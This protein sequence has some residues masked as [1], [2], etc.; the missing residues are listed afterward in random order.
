MLGVFHVVFRV[1]AVCVRMFGARGKEKRIF[2][3]REERDANEGESFGAKDKER[4]I[5]MKQEGKR[6]ESLDAERKERQVKAYLLQEGRRHGNCSGA[7]RKK[8]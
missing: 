3:C 7:E 5:K 1:T 8:R 4:K 6:D 2:G